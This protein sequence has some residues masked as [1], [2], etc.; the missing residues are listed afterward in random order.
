MGHNPGRPRVADGRD[1]AIER[2][3]RGGII[4]ID[5]GHRDLNLDTARITTRIGEQAPQIVD[6]AREIVDR[7]DSYLSR[8]ILSH[9][10]RG[11]D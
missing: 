5:C 3:N 2:V 9:R 11:G 6:R 10:R 7:L 4:E 8:S 1:E